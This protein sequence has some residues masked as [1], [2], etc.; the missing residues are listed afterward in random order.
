MKKYNITNK[1]PS[2]TVIERKRDAKP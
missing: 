1:N 2:L